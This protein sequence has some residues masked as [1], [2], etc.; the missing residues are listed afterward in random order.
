ME[1]CLH[2]DGPVPWSSK[3][4]VASKEAVTV[5]PDH[6]STCKV[7]QVAMTCA[8][9]AAYG[10]VISDEMPEQLSAGECVGIPG[11]KDSAMDSSATGITAQAERGKGNGETTVQQNAV[12]CHLHKPHPKRL[13]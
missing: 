1:R 9:H 11:T 12:Q 3:T 5:C 13:W 10:K 6:T 7:Q 8:S 2:R 4:F